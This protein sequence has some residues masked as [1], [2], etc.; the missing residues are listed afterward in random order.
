MEALSHGSQGTDVDTHS[1]DR[2]SECLWMLF[3]SAWSVGNMAADLHT[4]NVTS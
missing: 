4:T 2:L 3:C 1:L